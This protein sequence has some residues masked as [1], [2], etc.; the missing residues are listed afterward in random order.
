VITHSSYF[1]VDVVAEKSAAA[2]A[3]EAAAAANRVR[4]GDVLAEAS[5]ASQKVL[6]LLCYGSIE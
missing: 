3:P 5:V 4:L 1:A 6:L 2:S